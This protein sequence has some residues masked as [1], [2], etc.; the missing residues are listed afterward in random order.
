MAMNSSY[1]T[2]WDTILIPSI[3]RLPSVD[4]KAKMSKSQG[5]AIVLSATDQE[6][7]DAVNQMYTDPDHRRVS[8]PGRVEGNIVFVYLDAFDE[9]REA[10]AELKDH[11][12]RGGIGDMVLKHRLTSIL[13]TLIAPIRERRLSLAQ[14]RDFILDV[15]Q[16]GAT[17]GRKITESTKR[18]L[19]DALGAFHLARRV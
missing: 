19:M 15:L 11:Y 4:G 3:G 14:D 13:Q 12:R 2:P 10:V 1:T 8:D 17:E 18:Q 6:I 16:T 9:D 5:N 7:A